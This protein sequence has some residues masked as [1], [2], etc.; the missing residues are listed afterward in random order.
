MQRRVEWPGNTM[1]VAVEPYLGPDRPLLNLRGDKMIQVQALRNIE[2]C[3]KQPWTVS[4]RKGKN[5]QMRDSQCEGTLREEMWP[6]CPG[7]CFRH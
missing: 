5:G 3:S 4:T 6:S 1:A 7:Q 2:S